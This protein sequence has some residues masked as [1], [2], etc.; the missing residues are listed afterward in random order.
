L[1][2]LTAEDGGVTLAAAVWLA[3]VL[4]RIPTFLRALHAGAPEDAAEIEAVAAIATTIMILIAF[5]YTLL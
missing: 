2:A 4:S 1:L 5:I 3:D